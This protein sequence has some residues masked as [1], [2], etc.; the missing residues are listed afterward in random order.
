M[1]NNPI[2]GIKKIEKNKISTISC[3]NLHGKYIKI[4]RKLQ[5]NSSRTFRKLFFYFME[6]PS[7]NFTENIRIFRGNSKKIPTGV[8]EKNTEI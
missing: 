7:G 4:P 2:F 8:L 3:W 5:E 1:T 6:I